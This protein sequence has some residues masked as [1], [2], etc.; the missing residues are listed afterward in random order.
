MARFVDWKGIE[1]LVEAFASVVKRSPMA[2][3]ELIGDGELFQATK[4]QVARL[5]IGD[6]VQFHGRVPLERAEA[7]IRACD[8]YMAP[9]LRECGGCALLECM[10]I[11]L[12]IISCN[13]AGPAEYLGGGCGVLVDPTSRQAFVDGLADAMIEL[14]NDPAKRRQLGAAA[15]A[16]VRS[17][18]YDWDSKTDRVLE[19]FAEILG[20]EPLRRKAPAAQAE[21]S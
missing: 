8:V 13:W 5:G 19:I 15:A 14:A 20:Q 18:Y 9:A 3:L 16:R 21:L 4:A 7:L 6:S 11:A 1:F 12:P 2:K 10:A 17:G